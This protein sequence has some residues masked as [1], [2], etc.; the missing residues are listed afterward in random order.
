M[1]KAFSEHQYLGNSLQ[2]INSN[3]HELNI[4]WDILYSDKEKWNELYNT[5]QTMSAQLVQFSTGMASNS[6]DWKESSDLVYNVKG[7]WEEPVMIVYKETVNCAANYLE[8]E[9]WLN[10][11]FPVEGFSPTQILRCDFMARNYSY[12]SVDNV[13]LKDFDHSVIESLAAKHRT[14]TLNVFNYLGLTNQLKSIITLI[15]FFFRKHGLKNYLINTVRDISSYHSLITYNRITDQFESSAFNKLNQSDL[16]NVHAYLYQ[17]EL[18]YKL[19]FKYKG[20]SDIPAED[21]L[22]FNLMDVHVSNAGNFFYKNIGGRW[23]YYPYTHIEFCTKDVC[24]DCYSPVDLNSLYQSREY[25]FSPATPYGEIRETPDT[26]TI[27][28]LAIAGMEDGYDI[29]SHL[30]S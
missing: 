24:T 14:T 29:I 20:L 21:L 16:R 23:Q 10:D 25:C 12:E 7:Y 2:I 8:I 17:Y 30:M 9:N 3:M 1:I 6:A 18:V 26:P 5:M 19:W 11:N 15:D 13:R 27:S 28:A 4:R 22:K